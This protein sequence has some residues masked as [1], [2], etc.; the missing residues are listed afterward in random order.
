[1]VKIIFA[2]IKD[3]NFIRDTFHLSCLRR[4]QCHHSI[5]EIRMKPQIRKV[6]VNFSLAVLSKLYSSFYV[7][8]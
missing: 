3:Q 1:M 5:L 4:K 7:G 2:K 8:L 6:N